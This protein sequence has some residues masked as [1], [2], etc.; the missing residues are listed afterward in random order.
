L[1]KAFGPGDLEE[2]LRP[3]VKGRN[4][5]QDNTIENPQGLPYVEPSLNRDATR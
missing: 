1:K 4:L 3:H 2:D 5:N